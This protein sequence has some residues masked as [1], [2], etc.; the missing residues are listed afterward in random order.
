MKQGL[1]EQERKRDKSKEISKRPFEGTVR[2]DNFRND[3]YVTNSLQA[4]Q[5][6]DG[7]LQHIELFDE[8]MSPEKASFGTMM[9]HSTSKKSIQQVAHV[10]VQDQD[11][12]DKDAPKS[13]R[14]S[15]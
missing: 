10:Q 12:Q 13:K 5:S 9:R 14:E 6:L 7:Q 2:P 11:Q 15:V 1:V 3:R 8:K 4:G